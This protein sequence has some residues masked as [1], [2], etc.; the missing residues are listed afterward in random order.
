MIALASSKIKSLASSKITA[1]ASS[2]I[3]QFASST[4]MALASSKIKLLA[5][6]KMTALASSKIKPLTSSKIYL[7][8]FM[9]DP[10]NFSSLQIYSSKNFFIFQKF[11]L[12]QISAP[13]TNTSQII[14]FL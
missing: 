13:M 11:L 1:L 6:S 4:K 7:T 14:P 5:L 8:F 10:R 12:L 2:K 9:N 3:K